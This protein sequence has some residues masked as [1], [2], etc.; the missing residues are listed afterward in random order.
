MTNVTHNGGK[1]ER[2]THLMT[3]PFSRF[4]HILKKHDAYFAIQVVL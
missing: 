2:Q 1:T 3:P 4:I